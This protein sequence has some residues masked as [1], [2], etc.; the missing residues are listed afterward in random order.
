MAS[1][2]LFG[3]FFAFLTRFALMNFSYGIITGQ[4]KSISLKNIF[5]DICVEAFLTCP[6]ILIYFYNCCYIFFIDIIVMLNSQSSILF[7]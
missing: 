6:F 1:F 7:L 4:D 5:D 2:P 3:K